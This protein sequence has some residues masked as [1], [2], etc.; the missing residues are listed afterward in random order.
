MFECVSTT[1]NVLA[2][3]LDVT[4]DSRKLQ[5]GLYRFYSKFLLRGLEGQVNNAELCRCDT[6]GFQAWQCNYG[7]RTFCLSWVYSRSKVDRIDS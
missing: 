2:G 3:T 6:R 7:V 4:D 1:T 5:P